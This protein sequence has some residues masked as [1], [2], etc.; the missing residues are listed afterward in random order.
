MTYGKMD[1]LPVTINYFLIVKKPS[2]LQALTFPKCSLQAA[3]PSL[4]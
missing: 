2:Q 3:A 4:K 1:G